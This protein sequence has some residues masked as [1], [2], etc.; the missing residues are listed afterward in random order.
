[1]VIKAREAFAAPVE[2][3]LDLP[4]GERQGSREGLVTKTRYCQINQTIMQIVTADSSVA[5]RSPIFGHMKT[6]TFGK[7]VHFWV[8]KMDFEGLNPKTENTLSRQ[9]PPKMV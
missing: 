8:Q 1:M 5:L 4:V 6:G 2:L 7:S 9:L 3:C